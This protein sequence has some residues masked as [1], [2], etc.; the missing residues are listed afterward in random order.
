M[1]ARNNATFVS[2]AAL[3]ASVV[4]LTLTYMMFCLFSLQKDI[5]TK[6]VAETMPARSVPMGYSAEIYAI[7]ERMNKVCVRDAN[8]ALPMHY[9]LQSNCPYAAW[10]I[11]K[12]CT[13]VCPQHQP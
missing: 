10:C 11:N 4:V 12:Q 13:I 3:A 5:D 8:C 2:F 9:A 7:A 1:L 6:K